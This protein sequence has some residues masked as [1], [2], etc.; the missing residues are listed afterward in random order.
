MKKMKIKPEILPLFGDTMDI[1]LKLFEDIHNYLYANEGLSEQHVLEEI[2]K[3][4]F[5]KIYD[6]QKCKNLFYI[7][8]AEFSHISYGKNSEYFLERLEKLFLEV[9]EK[10][11]D[12]FDSK[13]AL[14]LSVLSLAFVV[15]KLQ[16]LNF[17]DS[18]NDASS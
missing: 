17:R 12:F 9:K 4:L 16:S 13:D 10:Y 1:F 11:S 14:R 3:L 8:D 2:I 18:N 5:L 7:S 15:K 6:E